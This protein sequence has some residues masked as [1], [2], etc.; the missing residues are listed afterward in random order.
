MK[1]RQGEKEMTE[2]AQPPGGGEDGAGVK[3]LVV[4]RTSVEATLHRISPHAPSSV[5]TCCGGL[6]S[7]DSEQQLSGEGRAWTAFSGHFSF[8]SRSPQRSTTTTRTAA[9]SQLLS[10][11]KPTPAASSSSPENLFSRFF[12][13]SSPSPPESVGFS[14]VPPVCTACNSRNTS[15]LDFCVAFPA[16]FFTFSGEQDRHR[17]PSLWWQ[18][19]V[20]E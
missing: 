15:V 7:N 20:V 6:D 9:R 13:R 3:S 14:V 4:M 18:M 17:P 10:Q 1:G 12:C 19:V 8:L 5:P 2:S 16:L 11:S